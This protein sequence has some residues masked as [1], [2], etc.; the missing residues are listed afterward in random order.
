MERRREEAT[1]TAR[2]PNA[3]NHNCTKELMCEF[4]LQ[5]SKHSSVQLQPKWWSVLCRLRELTPKGEEFGLK[6]HI[7]GRARPYIFEEKNIRLCFPHCRFRAARKSQ[8]QRKE[9]RDSQGGLRKS[10]IFPC[11]SFQRNFQL[12]HRNY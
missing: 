12:R 7:S 3:I 4:A 11:S 1:P 8:E 2:R 6:I 10:H 9:G 5:M